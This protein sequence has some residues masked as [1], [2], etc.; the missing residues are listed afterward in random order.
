MD[1]ALL[2]AHSVLRWL[3]VGFLV[4]AIIKSLNGWFGKAAYA[5]SD[6]IIALVLLT[7]THL[8]LIAGLILYFIKGWNTQISNMAD[9]IAR[10][11]G[12]EHGLTMLITI[13]L[14]TVGRIKSKKATESIAKYKKGVIFYSIA[15]VLILWAGIVKPML[16]GKGLI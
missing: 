10:F 6:N 13:T 3:V 7:F 8:Q 11:W 12:M 1:I 15:L 14:I 16:L 5:K 9:P 4:I 2:Y